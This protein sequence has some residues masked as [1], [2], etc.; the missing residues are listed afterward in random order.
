M[1]LVGVGGVILAAG[2]SSRMGRDKALLPW[3]KQGVAPAG[4]G[5]PA[6]TLLSSVIQSFSELCDMVIVVAGKN[7]PVLRPVVEGC[8]AVIAR[9]P[10]PERGQFSSLQ[11]GLREVLERGR[12]AAMVTLVDRPP[13]HQKTLAGLITAFARREHGIWAIVPEYSGTHGHPILL[14]REMIEAFLKAPATANARE[15]EHTNQARV[16]YI[17]VDDP[18][19]TANVDTPQDYESLRI[20]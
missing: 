5:R 13:P 20:E 17:A 1:S 10:A 19:V 18:L 6:G 11:T 12:D 14:G 15:I 16:R 7:E 8:G 3:P 9:N 4:S 2:E